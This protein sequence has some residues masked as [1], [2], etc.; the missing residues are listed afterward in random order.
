MAVKK[1]NAGA[2]AQVVKGGSDKHQG[3]Q[4]DSITFSNYMTSPRFAVI[5]K[6]VMRDLNDPSTPSPKF[7]KYTK[8][9]IAGYLKDPARN[10]KQLRNAVIYLYGASAHFRRLIQYFVSLSDLSYVISPT[11]LDTSKANAASIKRNYRRVL[12]LMSGMNTKD[13]LEKILTVAFREDTFYGTIRETSD[14]IIIQQLPSDYCE[15]TAIEDNVL[16]VTFDFSYFDANK[17]SLPLYPEEFTVKYNLYKNNT[18]KNKWQELDSPWS[19]AVKANKDILAYALPP[20]AGILREIYDL[21]DYKDLRKT[22]EELENYALLIM[23]LGQN[24]N[25]DWKMEYN[26]ALEFY[27]NLDHVLPSEIGSVLSPMPIDKISFERTHTGDTDA[28]SDAEQNL[29]SSA[30]VSSLLFNNAKASANALSLSIKVDQALTYSIVKS[31]ESV[32]NRFIRRHGFGKNFKINFLD[33]SPF[34]RKEASDL[35]LKAFTYGAPTLSYYCAANGIDQDALDCLLFL[36]DDVLDFKSR[37]RPPQNSAQTG[38]SASDTGE[39]S[40]GRPK[41]AID[42]LSDSGEAWQEGQGDEE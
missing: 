14:S 34:N 39:K 1:N 36:E 31:I 12:D 42:E 10:E 29:F 26:K 4:V 6:M 28:V 11:K 25:G 21:E 40:S 33:V 19:F 37:L 3:T 35:Y 15:V 7:F 38:A 2:A 27:Q 18:S 5:N 24:D 30:G 9:Q 13:Q 16:N 32:L 41:A 23:H 17:S 22:K 8:E 20:F